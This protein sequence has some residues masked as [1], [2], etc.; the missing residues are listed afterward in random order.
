MRSVMT[1]ALLMLGGCWSETWVY[2]PTAQADVEVSEGTTVI[3]GMAV[4]TYDPGG[5]PD[6]VVGDALRMSVSSSIREHLELEYPDAPEG[7]S[8]SP[9]EG[10][11]NLDGVF[12]DCGAVTC[13]SEVAFRILRRN[14]APAI[15][16]VDADAI[17][18]APSAVHDISPASDGASLELIFP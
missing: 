10:A 16:S 18:T 15:L 3:D 6:E 2:A 11:L 13:T 12:P 8:H 14:A 9:G 4:L 7:A 5:I 17:L 1:G